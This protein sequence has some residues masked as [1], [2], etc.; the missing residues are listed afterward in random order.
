MIGDNYI[1]IFILIIIL[2]CLL[3]QGFIN[4]WLNTVNTNQIPLNEQL[5]IA[6]IPKFFLQPLLKTH[7]KRFTKIHHSWWFIDT[8]Y[9]NL[10]TKN[11]DQLERMTLGTRA[12]ATRNKQYHFSIYDMICQTKD[13]KNRYLLLLQPAIGRKKKV[14]YL[15]FH[16]ILYKMYL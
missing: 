9:V 3:N 8:G 12:L 16:L 5:H 7:F 11:R 6:E 1:I 10:A 2:Y 4:P 14:R 15:Y 13:C